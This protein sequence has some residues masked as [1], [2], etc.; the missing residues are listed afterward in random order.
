MST[1]FKGL[2]SRWLEGCQSGRGDIKGVE[3]SFTERY[4][5]PGGDRTAPTNYDLTSDFIPYHS[6]FSSRS[7][8]VVYLAYRPDRLTR[9]VCHSSG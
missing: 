9:E 6:Y 4:E 8:I 1:R 7:G 2:V 5:E 3:L